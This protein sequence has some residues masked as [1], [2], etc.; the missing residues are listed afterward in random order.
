MQTKKPMLHLRLVKL[1]DNFKQVVKPT[2]NKPATI[3]KNQDRDE[4]NILDL[5]IYI[6]DQTVRANRI[7]FPS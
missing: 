2:S 3:N 4:L 1:A 7:L 5:V 6:F